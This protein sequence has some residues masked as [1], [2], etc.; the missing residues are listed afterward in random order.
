MTMYGE[1]IINPNI[2]H[3]SPK[4]F[5]IFEQK[6]K[7]IQQ[8]Y[9]NP[10]AATTM[11]IAI[12]E[13]E[14]QYAVKEI[15]KSKLKE[16][17]QYELAKNELSI[18]YSLSKKSNYIVNVSDYFENENSFFL[19]MEYCNRPNYFQYRLENVKIQIS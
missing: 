11:H 16:K 7:I 9:E 3:Y 19:V 6:Y 12:D 4:N 15:K 18:H 2:L 5:D 17:Y 1:Q 14:S 10:L 13:N 8:F